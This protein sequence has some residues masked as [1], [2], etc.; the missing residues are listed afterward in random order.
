MPA[1]GLFDATY[2]VAQLRAIAVGRGAG[3]Y[4][5]NGRRVIDIVEGEG[6]GE[7][8]GQLRWGAYRVRWPAG[9]STTTS[10]TAP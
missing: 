9:S 7:E 6:G 10:V 8:L 4:A 1:L 2:G 5:R 3:H